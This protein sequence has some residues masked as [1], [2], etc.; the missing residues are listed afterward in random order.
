MGLF[1]SAGK[2]D[3][4]SVSGTAQPPPGKPTAPPQND[5]LSTVVINSPV[6]PQ[7]DGKHQLSMLCFKE[8]ISFQ[9]LNPLSS[10]GF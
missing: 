3:G 7:E 9:G 1:L 4:H 2:R 8:P 10:P 5:V 6:H